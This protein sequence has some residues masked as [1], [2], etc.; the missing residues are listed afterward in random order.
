MWMKWND[1]CSWNTR[2]ARLTDFLQFLPETLFKV[3][4][5]KPKYFPIFGFLR[6]PDGSETTL[7]IFCTGT[8]LKKASNNPIPKKTLHPF[9]RISQHYRI[10]LSSQL[11]VWIGSPLFFLLLNLV[12]ILRCGTRFFR[13]CFSPIYKRNPVMLE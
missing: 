1:T 3:S 6:F 8:K 5:E 12:Q 13:W 7:S 4:G 2:K 10:G 11:K 9:E